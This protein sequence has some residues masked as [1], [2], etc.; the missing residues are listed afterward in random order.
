MHVS[1]ANSP[2]TPVTHQKKQPKLSDQLNPLS[3]SHLLPTN[4]PYSV[5]SQPQAEKRPSQP[6]NNINYESAEVHGYMPMDPQTITEVH[7]YRGPW[8]P[9]SY[10]EGSGSATIK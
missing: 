1:S 6:S 10:M 7:G 2:V 4:Q 8:I 5:V 3:D 9:N